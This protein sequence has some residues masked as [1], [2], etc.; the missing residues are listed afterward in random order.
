MKINVGAFLKA[1]AL[2]LAH[3][4]LEVVAGEQLSDTGPSANDAEVRELTLQL[5]ASPQKAALWHARGRARVKLNDTVGA[6][7]D[8]SEAIR[9]ASFE[10]G[11]RLSRAKLYAERGLW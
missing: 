9:L 5:R 10:P 2:L 8:F 7:A 3:S 1:V 11:F 6:L 4:G